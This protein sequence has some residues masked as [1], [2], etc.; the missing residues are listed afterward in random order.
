MPLPPA[1][2]PL[3][4]NILERV[5]V[6][7]A[8]QPGHTLEDVAEALHLQPGEFRA[9]IEDRERTVDIGF[10][11]DVVSALVYRLAIDPKWLLTGNYD[12]AIHRHA[13][14]LGEDQGISGAQVIREYVA[15]QYRR[16][17][18]GVLAFFRDSAAVPSVEN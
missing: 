11:I 9:L 5:R 7:V 6:V 2:D 3:I 18:D 1:N 12:S 17:G 8:R 10:L 4:A 16:L 15:E 14:L 13:L